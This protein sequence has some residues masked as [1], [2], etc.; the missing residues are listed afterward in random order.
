MKY[1]PKIS[2]ERIYLSPM[3]SSDIERYTKWLND[4][5]VTDGLGSTTQIM[6]L[7]KEKQILDKMVLDSYNFAIIR[8]DDHELLG[9]AGFSDLNPIQQSATCGLF[10]GDEENR[11]KG[12]GT[13]AL[14]L[15]VSY[16]FNCLNLYNIM[17]KV[18]SFNLA[19]IACY[20]KVGFKIIGERRNSYFLNGKRY[21][22][23]FMDITA[24][25]FRN[26]MK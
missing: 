6:T 3:N 12:Y 18:F 14:R 2:G 23:V 21:N 26:L 19:A 20:K 10:I 9:S 8:A 25:D 24:D 15:L 11:G 7:E 16:G 5:R 1:F 22:D 17:L 13:E 4:S